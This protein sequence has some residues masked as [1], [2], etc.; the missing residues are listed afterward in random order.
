MSFLFW[1]FL[2]DVSIE[3]SRMNE[4]WEIRNEKEKIERDSEG[5]KERRKKR[6]KLR[7]K[8]RK[9]ERAREREREKRKNE[10]QT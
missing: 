10:I 2:N 8:E 6:K 9:K 1:V 7:K 3:E 5:R 4:I